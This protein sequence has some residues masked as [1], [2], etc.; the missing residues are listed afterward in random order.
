[1][2]GWHPALPDSVII[3]LAWMLLNSGELFAEEVT[4]F[5]RAWVI[6]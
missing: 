6:R 4:H 3:L 2:Q 1:M 5:L